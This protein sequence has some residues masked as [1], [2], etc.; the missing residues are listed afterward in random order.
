MMRVVLFT[1]LLAGCAATHTFGAA[2]RR[3]IVGVLDAQVA[4]WNRADL[5]GYMAGYARTP[6]LVFTSGG[7]IRTG[8]EETL[9]AYQKRYGGAP[10]TMGQL[11]FEILRV[12]PVGGDGAI[13]LGR[14]RL[15]G[16]PQAG[17]G[18]FS[19][20]LER[21]AEGWRIVHDHT[22]ADPAPP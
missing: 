4:A 12:Q 10:A 8:W 18:V 6:E 15:T 11:G 21:R 16:T 2:D 14:W 22:S 7:K 9:A 13:V 17:A 5:T 3:T 20:I 19:V 1:M